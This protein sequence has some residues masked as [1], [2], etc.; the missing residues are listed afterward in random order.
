MKNLSAILAVLSCL[1]GSIQAQIANSATSVSNKIL[2]ITAAAPA[3]NTDASPP[4]WRRI[5]QTTDRQG[6]TI[7][8][9][10]E[11]TTVPPVHLPDF[12]GAQKSPVDGLLI[13]SGSDRET[14]VPATSVLA[15]FIFNFA[16]VSSNSLSILD[17]HPSCGC[18]TVQLPSLP[19]SIPAGGHGRFSAVVHFE[20]KSGTLFKT[21]RVSTD[22]G[23]KTLLLKINIEPA[24]AMDPS[25]AARAQGLMVAKADRQAVFN[26]DCASCHR[27]HG[28]GK[29]G[30]ALYDADCGICHE[31][32]HRATMVPDLHA[33][34]VPTSEAFWL[35]WIAHGKP[36][37]LIPAFS[38]NDGGPLTDKQITSLADYLSAAIPAREFLGNQ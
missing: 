16:N 12:S 10:Q 24:I 34:K 17:V 3:N 28:D 18:T 21:I 36:G 8:E 38:R 1:V 6:N 20:G 25:V 15:N 27:R 37:S 30:N 19:W 4:V 11:I 13:W 14:N 35:E 31:G 5:F 2:G 26:G 33:L 7:Y 29:Y 9:T 32:E 22:R 23:S